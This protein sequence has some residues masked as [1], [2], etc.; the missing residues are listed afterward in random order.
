LFSFQTIFETSL[1]LFGIPRIETVA[2]ESAVCVG[3]NAIELTVE[4]ELETGFL[5]ILDGLND[6]LWFGNFD[7][8]I[9]SENTDWELEQDPTDVNKVTM[10]L[11][12]SSTGSYEIFEGASVILRATPELLPFPPKSMFAK[13]DLGELFPEIEPFEC[14]ESVDCVS[15]RDTS[16]L[17]E[18]E[19]FVCNASNFCEKQ[20]VN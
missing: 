11:P 14:C 2:G 7:G 5:P 1:F 8:T 13:A 6:G 10:R 4:T 16:E 3:D 9:L 19:E 17:N 12:R 20:L 15:K 18:G